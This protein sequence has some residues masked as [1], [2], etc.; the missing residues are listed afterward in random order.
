MQDNMLGLQ[1]LPSEEQY[2][3]LQEERKLEIQKRIAAERQAT[4][5]AQQREKKA[6]EQREQKDAMQRNEQLKQA[7]ARERSGSQ[8]LAGWIPN[9]SSQ[10]N[11][12]NTDDP[13]IQQ[14]NIIRS[15][16]KQAKQAGKLDE[17]QMLEQ[18]LKE[19]QNEYLRQQR[20]NWS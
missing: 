17:V 9:E 6:K 18:N 5:E 15:Y 2:L 11:F 13:M 8:K 14:M 3:K 19:L 10:I 16:I 20:Q 7:E 4:F 1:A 12:N